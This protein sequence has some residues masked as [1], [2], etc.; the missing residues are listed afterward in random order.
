MSDRRRQI[1][2]AALTV[3]G[4]RGVDAVTHRAVAAEAGVPLA[5]TTYYFGSKAELVQEALELVIARSCELVEELR[6]VT[7]TIGGDELVERLV[8]F[9]VAQIDDT[10]APLIAQYELM[11][12]SGRRRHLR[13]LAERWT[14]AYMDGL[15]ELVR[16]SPL[17]EP[18]RA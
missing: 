18:E 13:P 2:E 8:L 17:P 3:I 12:E 15:A 14:V 10:Q 7:G 9:A 6:A 4:R 16:A 1:V 11:L 5:A